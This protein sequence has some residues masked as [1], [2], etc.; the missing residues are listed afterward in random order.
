MD[1]TSR[2]KVGAFAGEECLFGKYSWNVGILDQ[3][4]GEARKILTPEQYEHVKQQVQQLA[5][6]CEPARSVTVDVRSLNDLWEIR[7][8]GGVL[9][10]LNIRL[11]YGQ[12]STRRCLVVLGCFLK[13]ADGKTPLGIIRRC[14]RRW[15]LYKNGEMGLLKLPNK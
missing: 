11:V 13:K 5:C 6:L 2:L 7:D 9:G 14:E 10:K 4:Y 1:E 8:K 15:R 3:A 12:D